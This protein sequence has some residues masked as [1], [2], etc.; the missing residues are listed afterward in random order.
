[1]TKPVN[2]PTK[3]ILDIED[4]FVMRCHIMFFYYF[5]LSSARDSLLHASYLLPTLAST[6]DDY[7]IKYNVCCGCVIVTGKKNETPLDVDRSLAYL[8]FFSL[9]K[10][11]SA[12]SGLETKSRQI[13]GCTKAK[14]P[15]F[16]QGSRCQKE[17]YSLQTDGRIDKC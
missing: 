11:T 10:N 12:G 6:V 16:I 17:L 15:H 14:R 1:M 4:N 8:M 3:F 7:R 13:G 9:L 2:F 5:I